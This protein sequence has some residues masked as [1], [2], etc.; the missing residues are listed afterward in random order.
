MA[1][2]SLQPESE[3]AMLAAEGPELCDECRIAGAVVDFLAI[4]DLEGRLCELVDGQVGRVEVTP[5]EWVASMRTV[6]RASASEA[7]QAIVDE[8]CRV[9]EERNSPYC[10]PCKTKEE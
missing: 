8:L 3:D 5:E 7:L 10:T 1:D 2:K 9:L 6:A 4:C